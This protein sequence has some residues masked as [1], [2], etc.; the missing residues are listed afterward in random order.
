M[1]EK[2]Q[3]FEDVP[4]VRILLMGNKGVGKTS[5]TNLLASSVNTPTPE[6][7]TVGENRYWNIQVRLHEYPNFEGM[8][9]SPNWTSSSSSSSPSLSWT[10]S[11]NQY[12]SFPRSPQPISEILYFVEFYDLNTSFKMSRENR[13]RLYRNIDGIILVYDCSDML[14]HDSLHDWLY[15]PLRQIAKNRNCR[16]VQ[17]VPIMV[18]GTKVDSMK[19]RRLRRSGSIANQL[20]AEEMLVNCLDEDTFMDKTRNGGKLRNF[21][22]KVVE[23]KE[24]FPRSYT[25]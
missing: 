6:S 3:H 25:R 13:Q 15:E 23:F 8:P 11:N 16:N 4:T 22:N 10:E 24:R 9:P 19:T 5:L 17:D 1:K 12:P 2:Q 21:L 14:S 7:R 18:V 20:D